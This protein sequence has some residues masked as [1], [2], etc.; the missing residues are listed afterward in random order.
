MKRTEEPALTVGE[1]L[2]WAVEELKAAE[3]D[4]PILDSRLLLCEATNLSQEQLHAHPETILSPES[5]Q[6]FREW[7]NR[8]AHREPLAYILGKKEFYGLSFEVSPAVLIPRPET[9]VLV[10]TGIRL[11]KDLPNPMVVDIGLGS[12]AIAIS[13]AK[14]LQNAHVYGTETSGEAL[15]VSMRNAEC[16]AIADRVCFLEGNLL[17]P[18]TG[19]LFDL[20]IAN[21]PYV[22]SAEIAILQPEVA[23]YEPR[24]ALDGGPDG[25]AYYR[26]IIPQAVYHLKPH[27]WLAMEVGAG[28]ASEVVGIL[29]IHGYTDICTVCDLAGIE[30][31]VYGRRR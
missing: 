9:E 7:I 6:K 17:D 14:Q 3:V 5:T 27:G 31:I 19:R 15:Q 8:R 21:P 25:L 11:I 1:L 24:Q 16:L 10:E 23:A 28:Q 22:P 4:T 2:A 13:I 29:T 30:R 12:G 20:V 18:L 26:M